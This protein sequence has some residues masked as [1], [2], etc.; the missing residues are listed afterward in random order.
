MPL[1][2][3]WFARIIHVYVLGN[4]IPKFEFL[5]VYVQVHYLE[6]MF[7]SSI[8]TRFV[9]KPE[10][11]QQGIYDVFLTSGGQRKLGGREAPEGVKPPNPRQIEHCHRYMGIQ[12]HQVTSFFNQ[13]AREI[14][15]IPNQIN[16]MFFQWEIPHSLIMTKF[17][18]LNHFF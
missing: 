3:N 18:M 1:Y 10:G 9:V 15:I 5:Q 14:C 16:A 17:P 11:G 12:H 4:L 6:S 2:E 7:F 8:S 13:L